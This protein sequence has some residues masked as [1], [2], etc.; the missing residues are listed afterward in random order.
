MIQRTT[1]SDNFFEV[2]V[3]EVLEFMLLATQ[4]RP[5]LRIGSVIVQLRLVEFPCRDTP[6]IQLI[7]LISC[8]I[9]RLRQVPVDPKKPE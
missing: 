8:S 2:S 6:R 3:F 5:A 9:L 1:S 4:V 7:K